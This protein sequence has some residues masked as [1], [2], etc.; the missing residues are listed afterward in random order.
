M[1][2]LHLHCYSTIKGNKK[3][4]K[5]YE[6]KYSILYAGGGYKLDLTVLVLFI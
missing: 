1:A 4:S 5:I 2:S 6:K 3:T